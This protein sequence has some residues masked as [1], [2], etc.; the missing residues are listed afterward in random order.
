MDQ[1]NNYYVFESTAVMKYTVKLDTYRILNDEEIKE[2]NQLTTVRRSGYNIER[3]IE[4]INNKDYAYVYSKL[5]E[6]FKNNNYPTIESFENNIKEN[7]FENN[8]ID[9]TNR[10]TREGDIYIYKFTLKDVDNENNK[11]DMSIIMKLKEGTDFVMSYA[12]E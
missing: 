12:F 7:L 1:Y 2:Y 4:A 10:S 5:D 9:T 6:T 3:C 11:K 8:E